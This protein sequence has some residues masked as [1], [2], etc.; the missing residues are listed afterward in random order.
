MPRANL[1]QRGFALIFELVIVVVVLLVVGLAFL[2]AGGRQK[3]TSP[4]VPA[5]SP[6]A[7]KTYTSGYEGASLQY[8]AR[9]N[10]EIQSD[11][12]D[13]PG[14][15]SLT[16]AS[17][18]GISI[19]FQTPRPQGGGSCVN[20]CH[21]TVQSVGSM[22]AST[23][24]DL[25]Q[26]SVA[27]GGETTKVLGAMDRADAERLKVGTIVP[28]SDLNSFPYLARKTAGS[29]NLLMTRPITDSQAAT[30][31][32]TEAKAIITSLHYK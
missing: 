2:G 25:V 28:F 8:P 4:A 9:W 7:L 23:G 6:P 19:Y 22:D 3:P 5:Q 29:Y 1:N 27:I 10:A 30:Q 15:A 24:L 18:S 11:P 26:E 31:D 13:G 32:F 20:D 17:P 14:A 21:Y 12:E 16:L